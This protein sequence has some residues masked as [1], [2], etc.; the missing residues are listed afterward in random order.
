TMTKEQ[1]LAE[2]AAAGLLT[3]DAQISAEEARRLA[4]QASIIPV[5]LGGKGQ[6]LDLGR[7]QR[8]FSKAQRKA[9]RLRD[10]RCRA[11][12]CD[13]PAAWTEAHHLKPW[14]EGGKTDLDDGICAC[15][16]HHHRL[17]DRAYSHELL[18]SGDVRFYRRR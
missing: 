2:L 18:A 7:S 10:K 11:E 9:M 3:G 15:N 4:C 13:I 12:G 6:I 1:L 5:V 17:H 8:L 14:S 16:F